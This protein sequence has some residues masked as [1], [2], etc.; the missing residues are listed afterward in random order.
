ML[1]QMRIQGTGRRL[2]LAAA[3][4]AGAA[5]GHTLVYLVA[6]PDTQARTTVLAETGHGYWSVAVAGAIVLGL[7]SLAG[8]AASHLL[9]GLGRRRLPA[10]PDGL[11]SLA[12]RLALLQAGIFMVQEAIERLTAGTPLTSLQ[13][14]RGMLLTGILVQVLVALGV[15]A[16]LHLLGRA[17]AAVGRALRPPAG[18]DR[19]LLLAQWPALPARG[20]RR[21]GASAH[22]R[23]PPSLQAS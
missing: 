16:V 19:H 15:A 9:A 1:S 5:F 17:A 8:T 21:P 13:E 18:P 12:R 11:G 10:G 7:L 3:A 23:A 6:V 14:H 20:S 4:L 2:P 22:I